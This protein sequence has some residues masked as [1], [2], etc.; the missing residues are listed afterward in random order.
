MKN[1]SKKFRTI[2]P[3]QQ[4]KTIP[5]ASAGDF[6]MHELLE[7]LLQTTG[8]A[9]V[10]ISSFSISEVAIRSFFR[11]ME[12]NTILQLECLFDLSVKR[13]KLGLL[14]FANNIAS[15]IAISKNHA[16]FILLKNENWQLVVMGTANFQVNDKNEVGIISTDPVLFKF[17]TQIFSD[18]FTKGMKITS[19]EFE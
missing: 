1:L 19:D 16:K 7:W 15:S 18:W 14:H 6:S 11:L 13:H 2:E 9:A 4:N 3:I 17:Y 5:F 10:H 8:P 12:S